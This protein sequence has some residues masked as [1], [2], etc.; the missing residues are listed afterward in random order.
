MILRLTR[1]FVAATT[2]SILLSGGVIAKDSAAANGDGQIDLDRANTLLAQGK[3]NEAIALYDGA[4]RITHSYQGIDC[5][6][7]DKNNYLSYY[8]RALAYLGSSRNHAAITDLNSVIAIQ[9]DFTAALLQRGKL[10]AWQGD[11]SNA[12]KDLTKV[13]NQDNLVFKI[14]KLVNIDP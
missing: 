7:K 2:V 4:I 3:Y 14:A 9:P 1:I 11:F 10:L 8:K 5:V 12:I 13:K 6:E